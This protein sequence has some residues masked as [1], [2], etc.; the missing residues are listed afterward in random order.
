MMTIRSTV[1][2]TL[3]C[4]FIVVLT[5]GCVM[6][7]TVKEDGNVVSKGYVVKTPILDSL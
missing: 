5:S 6:Q 2:L 7:R 4:G 3:V 1:R